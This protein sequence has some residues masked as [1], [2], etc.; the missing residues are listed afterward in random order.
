MRGNA[1]TRDRAAEQ[2][3]KAGSAKS[4]LELRVV[5]F[6]G[7]VVVSA[8]VLAEP[9]EQFDGPSELGERLVAGVAGERREARVVVKQA[10]VV[11]A[12]LEGAADR[13]ERVG[14]PLFVVGELRLSVKR[15]RR[16]T[17]RSLVRPA[18]CG[19][20]SE[21]GSVL[22]RF[23]RDFGRTNTSVPGGASAAS[24]SI[25]KVAFPSSTMY[26]ASWS[27]PAPSC[28]LIS[29]PPRPRATWMRPERRR[30]TARW[31]TFPLE[32]RSDDGA[33][34]I[35]HLGATQLGPPPRRIVLLDRSLTNTFG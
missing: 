27:D 31:E 19:A 14:V 11:T 25:S 10:R 16:T 33:P 26:S 24:P 15:P 1:A 9:R 2:T 23:R 7:A 21:D 20:D 35:T 12:C 17:G 28:S 34:M 32:R 13:F 29:V 18:G 5:T 6:G 3:T 8:R 4:L 22:G 30:T